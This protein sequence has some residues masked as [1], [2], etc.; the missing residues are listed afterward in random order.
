MVFIDMYSVTIFSDSLQRIQRGQFAKKP[1]LIGN[2]ENDGSIWSLFYTSIREV[3]IVFL[4]PTFAATV[5]DDQVRALYPGQNDSTVI[6]D[7]IRDQRYRW[8]VPKPSF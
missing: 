7:F 1:I 2:M 4:G 6:A 5:T 8:C 3:L